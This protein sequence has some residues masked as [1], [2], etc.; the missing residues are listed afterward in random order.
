MKVYAMSD[1]HGCL[2]QFDIALSRI[3]LSGDNKLILLGDYVH[4]FNSCGVIERIMELQDEYGKDKVIA[5]KGNHEQMVIEGSWSLWE[6]KRGRKLEKTVDDTKY[7][8]WMRKLP[9][10]HVE[11]KTIFCHA[12]VDEAAGDWWETGTDDYTFLEKYPAQTGTFYMD[13]VAG[14]I[15]TS[16]ISHNR[17]YHDIYFDGESHYFIDGTVFRSRKIPVLM[18]DTE[19]NKYYR[20]TKSGAWLILPY[21]EE[22][23]FERKTKKW[24]KDSYIYDY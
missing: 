11:G 18:L 13:I 17:K 8:E 5:L 16:V 21:A 14:H 19:R 7:I 10:Y 22:N 9:L 3:D 1:I 24:E 20:I 4:G 6:T 15:G 2:S 23:Y 12:G